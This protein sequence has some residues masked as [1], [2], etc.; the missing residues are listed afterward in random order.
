MTGKFG[1]LD[2]RSKTLQDI[3]I[4]F[5]VVLTWRKLGELPSTRRDFYTYVPLYIMHMDFCAHIECNLEDLFIYQEREGLS[6]G[7]TKVM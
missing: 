4:L 6:R 2:Y 3:V 7:F 5:L 1:M